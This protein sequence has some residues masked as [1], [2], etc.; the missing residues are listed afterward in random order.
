MYQFGKQACLD[1]KLL[2]KILNRVLSSSAFKQIDELRHMIHNL[3]LALRC[4]KIE[5]ADEART[6][7]EVL[8]MS[9]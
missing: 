5:F 1:R 9:L 8:H 3:V 7:E 6:V 2:F 4:K